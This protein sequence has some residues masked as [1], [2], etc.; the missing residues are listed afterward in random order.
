MAGAGGDLDPGHVFNPIDHVANTA[1]F[2]GVPSCRLPELLTEGC[3]REWKPH[4]APEF[5]GDTDILHHQVEPERVI[6][7]SAGPFRLIQVN[8]KL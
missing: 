8:K 3:K 4:A 7:F 5:H 1:A 6:E 2:L